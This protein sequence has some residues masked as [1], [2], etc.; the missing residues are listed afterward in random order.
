[1][2]FTTEMVLGFYNQFSVT[3]IAVIWNMPTLFSKLTY[4]VLSG[5]KAQTLDNC[6][7][8]CSVKQEI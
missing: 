1:M 4:L 5:L 8:C 2:S 7:V 3:I 6:L